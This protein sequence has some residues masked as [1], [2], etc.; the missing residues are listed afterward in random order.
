MNMNKFLKYSTILILFQI[1]FM[2]VSMESLTSGPKNMVFCKTVML[3][4][5]HLNLTMT[6]LGRYRKIVLL[7]GREYRERYFW[8][9]GPI[10]R[11]YLFKFLYNIVRLGLTTVTRQVC[12]ACSKCHRSSNRL[13]SKIFSYPILWHRCS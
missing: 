11:H 1:R 6:S 13:D 7:I 5:C 3:R 4:L 12:R 8:S 2:F 9:T 10:I